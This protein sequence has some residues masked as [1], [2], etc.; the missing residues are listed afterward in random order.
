MVADVHRTLMY[1]GIFLY[2]GN[3]KSPKGKVRTYNCFPLFLLTLTSNK[4]KFE[5]QRAQTKTWTSSFC[6]S[7]KILLFVT[8][9]SE[10]TKT[11]NALVHLSLRI[12]Y[13]VP[14]RYNNVIQ[15]SSVIATQLILQQDQFIVG[16]V[17]FSLF[18]YILPN[19]SLSK[20]TNHRKLEVFIVKPH[21][22]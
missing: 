22:C 9:V 5:R 1:G 3:V 2:P 15:C 17:F 7:F 10:K 16:F 6:T 11:N 18:F 21:I 20:I 4:I 19:L 13:S 14:A 12:N 8:F